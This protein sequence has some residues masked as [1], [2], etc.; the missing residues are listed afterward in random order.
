MTSLAKLDQRLL[1]QR[2]L[3][4]SLTGGVSSS[5]SMRPRYNTPIMTRFMDTRARQGLLPAPSIAGEPLANSNQYWDADLQSYMYLEDF[6]QAH[7]GWRDNFIKVATD[8]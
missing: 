1:D 6:F 4:Q 8:K 3:D 7:R 5:L 2:L